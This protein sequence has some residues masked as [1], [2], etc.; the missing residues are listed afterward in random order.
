M[1]PT[2]GNV[3]DLSHDENDGSEFSLILFSFSKECLTVESSS[4]QAHPNVL[5]AQ[6]R[7]LASATA[8]GL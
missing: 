1:L 7:R 4:I 2:R 5:G 6:Q 3:L 8:Y